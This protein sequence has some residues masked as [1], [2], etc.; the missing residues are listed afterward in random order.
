MSEV[1]RQ[2]CSTMCPAREDRPNRDSIFHFVLRA[3][4][5]GYDSSSSPPLHVVRVVAEQC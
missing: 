5:P 1:A 3:S 4:Q 2:R